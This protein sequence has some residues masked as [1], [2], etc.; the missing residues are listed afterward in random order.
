[1]ATEPSE[2]CEGANRQQSES[3]KTHQV[4]LQVNMIFGGTWFACGELVE[5]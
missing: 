3:K 5:A 1:M 2:S 4:R